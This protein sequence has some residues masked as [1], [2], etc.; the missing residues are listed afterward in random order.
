M[1]QRQCFGPIIMR[2]AKRSEGRG[3]GGV[4]AVEDSIPAAGQRVDPACSAHGCQP[5]GIAEEAEDGRGK[6]WVLGDCA[7]A[8]WLDDGTGTA[9]GRD[10]R[11]HAAGQCLK[12]NVAESVGVRWEDEDIHICVGA[13]ERLT[14]QHAGKLGRGEFAA[15]HLL[16]R[17]VSDD[18]E[19]GGDPGSVKLSLN[20]R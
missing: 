2:V 10:D 1:P 17:A 9:V 4:D 8:S 20:D 11:G 5:L 19:A 13:G 16:F 14:A 7:G 6:L 15:Q 18:E 3:I 12:H